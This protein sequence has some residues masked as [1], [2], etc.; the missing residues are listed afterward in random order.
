M[1]DMEIYEWL[2]KL[3]PENTEQ[4][5]KIRA[6]LRIALSSTD[7]HVREFLNTLT[8]DEIL[9]IPTKE[10]YL[11]YCSWANDNEYE[12]VAHN[13]FSEV[14][15]SIFYVKSKVMRING[16]VTRVYKPM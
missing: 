7:T 6:M 14:V 13:V 15:H 2:Y 9:Y 10:V 4:E 5:N 11:K 8:I 16:K 12:K 1:T 3:E